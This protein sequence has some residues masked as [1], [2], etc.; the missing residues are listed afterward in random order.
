MA[1]DSSE[2]SEGEAQIIVDRRLQ[3]LAIFSADGMPEDLR[4]RY[5]QAVESTTGCHSFCRTVL[6]TSTILR[7]GLP[8]AEDHLFLA[9]STYLDRI[10]HN[11][12]RSNPSI[13]LARNAIC[14]ALTRRLAED[15]PWT[16]EELIEVEFPNADAADRLA[17]G[18]GVTALAAQR[19]LTNNSINVLLA[20]LELTR[21]W[22]SV[23]YRG[24]ERSSLEDAV[25]KRNQVDALKEA[26]LSALTKLPLLGEM[27][28]VALALHR[29]IT[30]L[31]AKEGVLEKM[32]TEL[33]ERYALASSYVDDY[34]A[35]VS[36]WSES[37]EKI[38]TAALALHK[39]VREFIEGLHNKTVPDPP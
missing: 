7:A 5:R 8:L 30:A 12:G 4:E 25:V 33:K 13:Q 15:A 26:L 19:N 35:F 29:L 17:L 39:K 36:Q 1:S 38:Q 22:C 3:Q 32:G 6:S 9:A 2:V 16:I 37:A 27:V 18:I 34:L 31:M 23:F 11:A 21:L 24:I 10:E 20:V 28:E 14:S